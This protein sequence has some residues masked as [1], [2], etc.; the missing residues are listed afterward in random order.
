MM[1]RA[2]ICLG[3]SV[4]AVIFGKGSIGLAAEPAKEQSVKAKQVAAPVTAEVD[5]SLEGDKKCTLCHNEA[6]GHVLAIY[7]TKHGVKGDPRTPGCQSCHG[8]SAGHLDDPTKSPDVVFGAK[9]K[10]LSSLEARTSACLSCHESNVLPRHHWSGS[11]HESHGV[12]CT[13]C[14]EVHNPN[15]KVLNKLTQPEVC[16]SCH[17][18]ER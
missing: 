12:A 16:F 3:I 17:Q 2:I 15:Q 1:R 5:R 8:E 9:S 10:H 11:A 4:L 13:D 14:H 6:S 7:Q 18:N